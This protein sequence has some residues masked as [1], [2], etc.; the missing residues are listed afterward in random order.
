MFFF[1]YVCIFTFLVLFFSSFFL[2]FMLFI[3]KVPSRS[4]ASPG[5]ERVPAAGAGPTSDGRSERSGGGAGE[6]KIQT[7]DGPFCLPPPLPNK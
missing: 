4:A 2:F 3:V 1:V 6:A 7:R 5:N